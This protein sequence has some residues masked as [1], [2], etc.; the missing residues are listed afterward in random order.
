MLPARRGLGVITQ[1]MAQEPGTKNV[2]CAIHRI[3]SI[4]P[5][6]YVNVFEMNSENS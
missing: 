6:K 3:S 4:D 1:D 5:C 2:T